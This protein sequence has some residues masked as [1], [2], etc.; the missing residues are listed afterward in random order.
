MP[1]R[2]TQ[3]PDGAIVAQRIRTGRK[4]KSESGK[5]FWA[6]LEA[7]GHA[8]F[9]GQRVQLEAFY[10]ATGESVKIVPYDRDK[11]LD[12][13]AAAIAGIERG[14]FTPKQSR[15]CPSCQFY[16]ICTSETAR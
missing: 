8:V 5:A 13:Y 15:D 1:D 6:F 12:M 3:T 14:A 2:V 16:F 7:A 9:S 11:S 4:T 10:P